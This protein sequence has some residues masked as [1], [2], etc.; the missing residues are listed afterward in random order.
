[1]FI[2]LLGALF[3]WMPI[4]VL[5]VAAAIIAGY[6]VGIFIVRLE[7]DRPAHGDYCYSSRIAGKLVARSSRRVYL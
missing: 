4:V 6:C 2:V 1:M 3:I 7:A 5:G